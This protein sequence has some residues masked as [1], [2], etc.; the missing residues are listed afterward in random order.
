MGENKF[1]KNVEIVLI[2]QVDVSEQFS[3]HGMVAEW[4]KASFLTHGMVLQRFETHKL[5]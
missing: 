1:D 2:D 5:T 4:V 3:Y